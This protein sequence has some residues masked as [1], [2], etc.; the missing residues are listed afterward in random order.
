MNIFSFKQI[1]ILFFLPNLIS[2]NT[3]QEGLFL[4]LVSNGLFCLYMSVICYIFCLL[5]VPVIF[6]ISCKFIIYT[7][8]F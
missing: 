3:P 6:F 5:Y 7:E 1:F 2:E 4:C 8:S